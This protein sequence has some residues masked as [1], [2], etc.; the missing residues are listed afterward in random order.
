[1]VQQNIFLHKYLSVYLFYNLKES[2]NKFETSV[3]VGNFT[4]SVLVLLSILYKEKKESLFRV[5]L[6]TT[7]SYKLK[8]LYTYCGQKLHDKRYSFCFCSLYQ[9]M[10]LTIQYK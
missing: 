2:L 5:H 6:Q 3:L 10:A 1:M 4:S 7:Q 9:Q 8:S